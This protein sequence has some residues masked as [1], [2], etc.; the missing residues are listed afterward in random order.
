MK[1]MT[2]SDY[3]TYVINGEEYYSVTT[4]LSHSKSSEDSAKLQKWKE[5]VGDEES[6]RI[7]K[8]ATKRGTI[9]HGWC[10]DYLRFGSE[11][12]PSPEDEV[13]DFWISIRPTLS[14][15]TDV[16]F[17]EVQVYH[18]GLKYAG[19]LDCYASFQGV[20][21]TLIDFKTAAKPK[22]RDWINDYFLQTVAYAAG[23]KEV[24]GF[25]TNQAAIIIALPDKP[26]QTFVLGRNDMLG[27]WSEWRDRVRVFNDRIGNRDGNGS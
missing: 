14:Q 17:Q 24:Y 6:E 4:I 11:P 19:T 25:S 13:W 3:R 10:E 16:K 9:L 2:K 5:R 18:K 15:V 21:N 22:R 27:L 7:K 23:V 8:S 26:A 1:K 20:S 12:D